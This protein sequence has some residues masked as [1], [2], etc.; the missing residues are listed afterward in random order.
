M[1]SGWGDPDATALAFANTRFLMRGSS[2]NC[3]SL[4]KNR[5]ALFLYRG[6][7]AR[8]QYWGKHG[9][10]PLNSVIFYEDENLVRPHH[11][12]GL[13]PA[14]EAGRLE[15]G[16]LA[17]VSQ[18]GEYDFVRGTCPKAYR[19]PKGSEVVATVQQAE[20][21]LV[22][23]RPIGDD[24]TDFVVLLDRLATDSERLHPHVVFQTVFE[25]RIGQD[26]ENEDRGSVVHE[27]QWVIDNAPCVT[28]TNEHLY[29]FGGGRQVQAHARAFLKTIFP[30]DIRT[31]KIGGQRHFMDGIDGRGSEDENYYR[32]F[33]NDDRN[34]QVLAG[35]Y[36]RFHVVP[37]RASTEHPIL[38]AIEAADSKVQ[39]PSRMELLESEGC[40]A[41]QVGPNL[42][43]FSSDGATLAD[44]SATATAAWSGRIVIADLAAAADHSLSVGAA[45][46]RLKAT[47]AGTI[48]VPKAELSAGD[49]L[50]V[51]QRGRAGRP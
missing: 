11:V 13:E 38:T 37:A 51:K 12:S 50:R 20:R 6:M 2:S 10:W 49:T 28:V 23:L 14:A 4:W 21:T 18:S 31:L 40:L 16:T 33:Q 25:P 1:R 41:A 43:V 15:V 42:I 29:D 17:V 8:H 44:A 7:T 24:R 27:G 26:W 30:R 47:Q 36:W 5:G 39:Q 45:N 48:C 35:G 9:E 32:A 34:G 3:F 22:Y 46:I 19:A